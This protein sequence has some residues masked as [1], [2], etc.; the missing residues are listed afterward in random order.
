MDFVV[1]RVVALEIVVSGDKAVHSFDGN[2]LVLSAHLPALQGIP[3]ASVVAP[4]LNFL[5]R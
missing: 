5:R 4:E 1:L 2:P 3:V